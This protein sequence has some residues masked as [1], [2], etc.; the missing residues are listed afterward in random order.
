MI[1]SAIARLFLG[2]LLGE[3]VSRR[4][5]AYRP[6]PDDFVV[7]VHTKGS[8]ESHDYQNIAEWMM[9]EEANAALRQWLA[10]CSAISTCGM[11]LLQRRCEPCPTHLVPKKVP[12]VLGDLHLANF[13]ILDGLVVV[14]D[15][16]RNY[17]LRFAANARAMRKLD[18]GEYTPLSTRS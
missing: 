15:Y 7:K 3:G 12:K 8:L 18:L 11:A 1:E 13:G 2:E 5:F 9:W 17:A 10:P 14:K 4:V 16:G 6:A